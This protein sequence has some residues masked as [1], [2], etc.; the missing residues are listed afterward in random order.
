MMLKDEDLTGNDQVCG[1]ITDKLAGLN[2]EWE[3]KQTTPH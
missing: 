2:I 1:R 3:P